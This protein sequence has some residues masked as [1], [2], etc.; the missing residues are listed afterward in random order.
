MERSHI[1][2][3]ETCS[4]I[5]HQQKQE[6]ES[7]QEE[8][9]NLKTQL[10]ELHKELSRIGLHVGN[11]HLG[12]SHSSKVSFVHGIS[13]H[14]S[15]NTSGLTSSMS[16]G[17]RSASQTSLGNSA[18][19]S[20]N[21]AP[22]TGAITVNPANVMSS[23]SMSTPNFSDFLP[24]LPIDSPNIFNIPAQS[25][26]NA[27]ST[28][29]HSPWGPQSAPH[30]GVSQSTPVKASS[31]NNS[32]PTKANTLLTP[33]ASFGAN[34]SGSA[35]PSGFPQVQSKSSQPISS[36]LF[37]PSLSAPTANLD[38]EDDVFRPYPPETNRKK[39]IVSKSWPLL[40][41]DKSDKQLSGYNLD[42]IIRENTFVSVATAQL[43]CRFLQKKLEESNPQITEAIFNGL[44]DHLDE[45]MVN[46]FGNYL[47][48]RLVENCNS[49][50]RDIIIQ[51]IQQHIISASKDQYGTQS[52]QKILPYLNQNQIEQILTVVKQDTFSMIKHPKASYLIQ[53]F[54][55]KLKPSNLDWLY[56][57]IITNLEPIA[58]DKVGCVIVK[59]ALSTNSESLTLKLV[60]KICDL[61]E[62]FVEDPFANYVVQTMLQQF[63]QQSLRAIESLFGKFVE[64]SQKKCSSPVIERCIMVAPET[65]KDKIIHEIMNHERFALLANHKYANFV[66]QTALMFASQSTQKQLIKRLTPIINSSQGT[67]IKRIQ[68]KIASLY[69][70]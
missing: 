24:Y 29:D 25:G 8:I 23:G 2:S 39:L 60:E 70:K 38:H 69:E 68:K 40:G 5:I 51:K 4:R 49:Q 6:I 30:S 41:S 11:L 62:V 47:F 13:D 44:I 48:T 20:S 63:P 55:D 15:T 21:S 17:I 3:P 31:F 59:K 53:Y 10:Q 58:R 16:S 50:Q 43:G 46:Q 64:L 19:I 52:L 61:I 36:I 67:C 45:L 33:Q 27:L 37:D 32:A 12:S 28:T 66:I 54:L 35:P 56:S 22:S 9:H 14:Q 57:V 1:H 42:T 65:T 18:S 26:T 34:Q 7:Q